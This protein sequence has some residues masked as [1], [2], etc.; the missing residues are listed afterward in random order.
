MPT[1]KSKQSIIEGFFDK[2]FATVAKKAHNKAIQNL[3][4]KDP[5][6][7]KDYKVLQQLRDKME[8]DMKKKAKDTKKK[9]K[10]SDFDVLKQLRAKVEQKDV[11]EVE[12]VS[13]TKSKKQKKY[14]YQQP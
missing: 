7:A 10:Q 9:K 12:T 5:Q 6:F 13:Q 8:K 2:V 14:H 11:N 1:N 4:K 3:A